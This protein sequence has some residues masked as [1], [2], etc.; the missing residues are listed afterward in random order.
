MRLFG[1]SQHTKLSVATR[2]DVTAPQHQTSSSAKM[3]VSIVSTHINAARGCHKPATEAA[4]AAAVEAAV[5]AAATAK[6]K[7]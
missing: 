7:I 5:E 3:I 6:K 4:V 1:V 2:V